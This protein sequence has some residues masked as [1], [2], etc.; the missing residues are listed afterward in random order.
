MDSEQANSLIAERAS[1]LVNRLIS[2]R[3][4]DKPP[5]LSEEFAYLLG[6]KNIEKSELGEVDAVLVKLYDGD[7]IKLN[8]NHHP[9]RQN[10]SCAHEIGH[11]LFREL[12]Q[13][14]Q[15]Y[16]NSIEYRTFNPSASDKARYRAKERLCNVAATEL[17]MPNTIFRNYL[18]DLGASIS[19][20]EK[21]SNIFRVSIQATARRIA[22]INTEACI[23][24]LW[25][26]LKSSRNRSLRLVWCVGP[27]RNAI[28]KNYN[29]PIHTRITYPSTLHKAYQYDSTVT[30]HKL[31]KLENGNKRLR[32]ESKGFGRG[33]NRY[34]VSLAFL[35]R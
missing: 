23:S 13:Q 26:L 9:L 2:K 22:E 20:I 14:M 35:E 25:R 31:F 15:S 24:L 4:H 6:I 18:S 3:G 17:L 1:Q 30:C 29:I 27:G 7:V 5:F 8:K 19:S 10:F 33:E 16:I 21:L 28:N 34:V 12:N 32:M 11:I